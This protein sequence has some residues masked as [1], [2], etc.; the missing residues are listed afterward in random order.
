ME[1]R[2]KQVP[3]DGPQ[4]LYFTAMRAPEVS[5]WHGMRSLGDSQVTIAAAKALNCMP[6]CTTLLFKGGQL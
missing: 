1:D 6:Y 2:N 5:G 3:L 4:Q